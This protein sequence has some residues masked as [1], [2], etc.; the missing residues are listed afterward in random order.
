M[1]LSVCEYKTN[2]KSKNYMLDTGTWTNVLCFWRV[3]PSRIDALG[4]IRV[5][6]TTTLSWHP[7]VEAQQASHMPR[8]I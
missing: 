7:S 5:R 1:E 4:C 2:S 8:K 6:Q 3:L